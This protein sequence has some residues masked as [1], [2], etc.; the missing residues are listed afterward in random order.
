[1]KIE[2]GGGLRPQPGYINVDLT[3]CE[4][5][6]YQCNFETDKLPFADNSVDEVYSQHCFEHLK[7]LSNILNEII[8]VCK[9]GALVRIKT[10]HP[11]ND[12]ALCPSAYSFD[13][14]HAAF[15][16]WWWEDVLIHFWKDWFNGSPGRIILKDFRFQTSHKAKKMPKR[17][18]ELFDSEK[19]AEEFAN[20][21]FCNM[22]Y[23]FTMVA[24]VKKF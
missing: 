23:D 11:Q 7:H 18:I 15:S 6:D 22:L 5:V 4:T 8:R 13:K 20:Y 21:H 16:T 19:E 24:N 12:L 3:K 17:M 14:H 2:L 10:P 1:M 9:D